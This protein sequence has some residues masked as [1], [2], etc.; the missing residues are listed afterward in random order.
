[1]NELHTD[2]SYSYYCYLNNYLYPQYYYALENR[3]L[4]RQ[5]IKFIS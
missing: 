2:K 4:G 1:M 5:T 3:Y